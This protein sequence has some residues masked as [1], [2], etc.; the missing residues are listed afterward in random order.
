[1]AKGDQAMAKITGLPEGT[2]VGQLRREM[3]NGGKFV[4]YLILHFGDRVDL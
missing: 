3:Q 1:M 2:S 4:Y